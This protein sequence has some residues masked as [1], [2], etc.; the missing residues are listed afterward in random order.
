MWRKVVLRVF[1]PTE[2][3]TTLPWKVESAA[4][5][6]ADNRVTRFRRSCEESLQPFPA[7][8]RR[9]RE[10][11]GRRSA[12]SVRSVLGRLS[13]VAVAGSNARF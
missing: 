2:V 1:F 4:L 6:L 3:F 7:A 5:V 13:C 9:P 11:A 10:P 8:Q 12:H